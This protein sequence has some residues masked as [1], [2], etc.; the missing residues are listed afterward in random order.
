VNRGNASGAVLS[1]WTVRRRLRRFERAFRPYRRELMDRYGEDAAA[2]IEDRTRREYHT[3]LPQTPRF[4]GRFNLFNSVIAAVALMVALFRAMS[5][6]G[7]TAEETARVLF[8]ATENSYRSLPVWIRWIVRRLFFRRL[9]LR[10]ARRSADHARIHPEGWNIDYRNGDG[11]T[12][13]WFFE[14]T[15]CGAVD[16]MRKHGAASLTPYCNYVDYIQSRTFGLGMRNPE[17]IGQGAGVCREFFKPRGPTPLP[18]NL[19][20]IA[21]GADVDPTD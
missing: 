21:R 3:I 11:V 2:R 20:S 15:R 5:A 6:E 8:A 9:F 4:T 17:N 10:H 18:E 16:F 19:R 14:C 7:K 12:C 1:A 13:D